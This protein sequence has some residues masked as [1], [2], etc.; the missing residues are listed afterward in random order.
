MGY[1]RPVM[2][3]KRAK[4]KTHG[5]GKSSSEDEKPAP[6]AKAPPPE[7]TWTEQVDGKDDDAFAA[8]AMTTRFTKG[9]LL[10]HSKFGKGVVTLVEGP[11]IEVLFQD[12]SKKLGHGG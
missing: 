2:S 4:Q 8:Y 10:T 3:I 12:G 6:W 11:R 5:S 7:K 1:M 9:Q